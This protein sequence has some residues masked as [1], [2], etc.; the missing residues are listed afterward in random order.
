MENGNCSVRLLIEG[1]RA[2]FPRPEFRRDH[3]TYETV[4]PAA[5]RGVLDKIYWQPA[6]RWIVDRIHILQPIR[7]EVMASNETYRPR[8]LILRDV[9]YVVEAHLELTERAAASDVHVQHLA[10]F[11]NVVSRA[12][13]FFGRPEFS[14]S[15][16]L[17]ENGDIPSKTSLEN[18]DFGWLLHGADYSDRGRLRF[19]RAHAFNG[20]IDVPPPGSP[21]LFG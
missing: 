20:A 19:F 5:A 15:T 7:L 4:T 11:R 2:F 12:S 1:D 13:V 17:I 10:N 14:A 6:I 9:S 21:D 16:R 8:T 18:H 3:V